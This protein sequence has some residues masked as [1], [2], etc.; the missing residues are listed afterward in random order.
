MALRKEKKKKKR[1][2]R[3]LV[4]G[5]GG[6]T[7]QSRGLT[8]ACDRILASVP[9]ESFISEPSDELSPSTR[10]VEPTPP[11]SSPLRTGQRIKNPRLRKTS[12]CFVSSPSVVSFLLRFGFSSL[13]TNRTSLVPA[14]FKR[15][16]CRL[17]D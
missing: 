2:R 12:L 14:G 3:Q 4:S 8:M 10:P 1:N 9:N 17:S 5:S 15:L 11:K 7:E 13:L 6:L 16:R